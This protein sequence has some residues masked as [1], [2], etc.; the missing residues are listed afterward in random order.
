[1][2]TRAT[3][4]AGPSRI[5]KP[6]ASLNSLNPAGPSTTSQAYD[7]SLPQQLAMEPYQPAPGP[8]VQ[9]A[10]EAPYYSTSMHGRVMP[11][12]GP[13]PPPPTH[14]DSSSMA[15]RGSWAAPPPPLAPPP[16]PTTTFG[17]TS[18]INKPN[19]PAE[20]VTP[21]VLLPPRPLNQFTA[22]MVIPAFRGGGTTKK[23][24]DSP[25][26]RYEAFRNASPAQ[27]VFAK[28]TGRGSPLAPPGGGDQR[29]G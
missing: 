27:S 20:S 16:L 23:L 6:N 11:P 26:P 12:S 15:Y 19:P 21:P 1:M 14:Y 4:N 22:N 10:Y 13:Y 8:M 18:G 9:Y 17:Q 24:T 28:N 7:N 25:A 3:E 2:Q 29:R 5:A